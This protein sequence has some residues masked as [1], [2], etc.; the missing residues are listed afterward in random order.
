M[1]GKKGGKRKEEEILSVKKEECC[2][3]RGEGGTNDINKNLF[4]VLAFKKQYN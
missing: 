1:K 2:V 4:L 3:W